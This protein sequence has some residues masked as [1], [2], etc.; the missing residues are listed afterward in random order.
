MEKILSLL[1]RAPK[2][3]VTSTKVTVSIENCVI[4]DGSQIFIELCNSKNEKLT[5]DDS[6]RSLFTEDLETLVI[7]V[8]KNDYSMIGSKSLE[9]MK[10]IY[11]YDIYSLVNSRQIEFHSLVEFTN[12]RFQVLVTLVLSEQLKNQ[13]KKQRLRPVTSQN[14]WY[15]CF[16][17]CN[18]CSEVNLN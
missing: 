12:I 8:Y 9:L 4:L 13:I 6:S 2:S 18:R 1:T 5:V 14:K 15:S 3:K 7:N 10:K 11:Y 16:Q 17:A